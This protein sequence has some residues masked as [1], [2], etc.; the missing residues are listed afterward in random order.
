MGKP[1]PFDT[2][3]YFIQHTGKN[4]CKNF[5]NFKQLR[6]QTQNQGKNSHNPQ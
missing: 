2:V 3:R 4:A 1:T 6:L 5:M